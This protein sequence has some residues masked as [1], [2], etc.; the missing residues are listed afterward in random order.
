MNYQLRIFVASAAD[1]P[2]IC[3]YE[4]LCLSDYRLPYHY[5]KSAWTLPNINNTC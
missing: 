2:H 3:D 1:P 5:Y 4:L